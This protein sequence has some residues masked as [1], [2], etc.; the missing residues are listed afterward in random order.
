MKFYSR[1]KYPKAQLNE[2]GLPYEDI[3]VKAYYENGEPYL[4][5]HGHRNNYDIIQAHYDDTRIESIVARFEAGDN[6]VLSKLQGFYA[7]LTQ[8][9]HNLQEAQNAMIKVQAFYDRMPNDV[10]MKYDLKS[11]I[12]SIGTDE[13]KGMLLPNQEEKKEVVTENVSEE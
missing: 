13:L 2:K 6:S 8:E 12:Q 9:A 7:D 11:F 4:E 10:K 5:K 1:S 3:L